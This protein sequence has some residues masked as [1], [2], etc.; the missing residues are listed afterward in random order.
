M[1]KK[2]ARSKGYRKVHQEVKGYTPQEKKTM[3]IGFAVIV[4]LLFG[5]VVL[6][7]FIES[8]TLLKVDSEG[9]VKD[10][11]D[12]WLLC[13]VG[14]SS[15]KKYRKLAEINDIPGYT[16]QGTERGYTD[17]NLKYHVFEAVDEA[18]AAQLINVQS[19]NGEASE[20]IENYRSQM[21]AFAEML[22]VGDVVEETIDGVKTYAVTMEYR[23]EKYENPT[24]ATEETEATEATEEKE[25]EY[26][27]T[28]NVVLYMDS[29]IKGKCV[30]IN[31][32]NLG[33]DESVFVDRAALYD[34]ARSVVPSI[35][36][37][38]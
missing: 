14:D 6:P 1:A 33:D 24:E 37:A 36:L 13:N 10:A 12:N 3:I 31:A 23:S 32:M 26:D 38:N 17:D 2:S 28:Q 7:D 15:H 4:V 35:A 21:A 11:G 5:I 19:G 29:N 18:A 8:F 27:Y 25:P 22:Y 9:M 16:L 30:V 20:L 34:V